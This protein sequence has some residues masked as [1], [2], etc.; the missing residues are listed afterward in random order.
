MILAIA[1][2]EIE[3]APFAVLCTADALP[4]RTLVTGVGPVETAFRLTKFL[5]ETKQQFAAVVQFGVGGAYIVPE[6]QLQP[7]LMDICFAE[8]E[9]AGDLGICLEQTV[10][11]LDS[12]LTGDILYDLDKPLAARCRTIFEQ[13]GISYHF[14]VFITVNSITG[15]RARGQMLQRRWNGMCENMEGAA[16]VRVCREFNLPA[17]ELR[18]ISNYVEDRDLATWCLPEAAAKAAH[19]AIQLVKGLTA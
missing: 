10:E 19:T 1:A 15:Y 9:V 5:C 6:Q 4:C 13:L 8:Q 14:G 17:A 7:A 16:V 12:S 18:C 11:Y 3:M 2:T